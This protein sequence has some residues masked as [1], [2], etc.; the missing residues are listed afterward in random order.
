MVKSNG[1]NQKELKT[2]LNLYSDFKN[3]KFCSCFGKN[4]KIN[5]LYCINCG[6]FHRNRA[7]TYNKMVKYR[8]MWRKMKKNAQNKKK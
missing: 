6:K 3:T 8:E 4:Y 2:L 5:G 7:K 1:F